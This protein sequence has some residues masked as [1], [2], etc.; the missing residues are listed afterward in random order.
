MHAFSLLKK[1]KTFLTVIVLRA[2]SKKF[3]ELN[4]VLQSEIFVH[5]NG[6]LRASHL[7]L[8]CVPS[9]TSYQDSSSALTVSS[10]LLSYLD[11]RLPG[12]LP[13][14]LMSKEAR[15][16][17]PRI[18]RHDSL[19]P[20]QDGSRDR[21][22]QGKAVHIPLEALVLED[23]TEKDLAREELPPITSALPTPTTDMVQKRS[24]ALDCWFSASQE[25]GGQ[26]SIQP[27]FE[28]TTPPASQK[29]KK[30]QKGDS[31][32]VVVGNTPSA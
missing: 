3:L 6:Q 10:P 14:G 25:S 13:R 24:M 26:P 22:F 5:Y 4:F 21:V 23:P 7:I 17:G 18:V 29:R 20:I 30:H 11:I 2:V 12:F 31:S 32:V 15:Q 16:L 1:D 28:Q 8:G 19:K 27:T 9:Y